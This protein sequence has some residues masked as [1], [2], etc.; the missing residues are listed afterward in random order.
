MIDLSTEAYGPAMRDLN[1][2]QRKFV[3]MAMLHPLAK[4]WQIAKAAGYSHRSH[5]ALR[6][7]AHRLFHNPKVLAAI[8]ELT[9]GEIRG[10]GLLALAAMKTIARTMN[11]KDQLKAAVTLAG[12]AGHTVE[13]R[14]NVN[15][16][17]TDTSAKSILEEI[18]QLAAMTGVPLDRL[19]GK[20]VI[21]AEFSEVKD[22]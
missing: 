17:I 5:G 7:T 21:E 14:I 3:E 22:G 4:D 2:Q 6:V 12:L 20:P 1:E 15:Q 18:R 19:L 16:T 11:H 8:K 9:D 10:S 13:Q